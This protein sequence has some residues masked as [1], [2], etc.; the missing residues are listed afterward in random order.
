MSQTGNQSD[1]NSALRSLY[2]SLALVTIQ[3]G[4]STLLIILA[5]IFV[6]LW[7]DERFGTS[8]W[9]TVGFAIGSIPITFLVMY[10]IVKS[11]T[12]RVTKKQQPEITATQEETE[13]GKT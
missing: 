5:A 11:V 1:K 12:Q 13:G 9:L 8:P 10:F 7:L 3:V 6:G 4:C 2:V